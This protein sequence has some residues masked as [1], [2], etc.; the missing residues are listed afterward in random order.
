MGLS[1]ATVYL[2]IVSNVSLFS[3]HIHRLVSFLLG[4]CNFISFF[5]TSTHCYDCPLAGVTRREMEVVGLSTATVYSKITSD[6]SLFSVYTYLNVS[7][8]WNCSRQ[9][10]AKDS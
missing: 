1:T 5:S 7:I 4:K 2:K 3:V 9:S 6:V 8:G 10:T